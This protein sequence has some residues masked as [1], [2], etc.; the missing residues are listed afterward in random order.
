VDVAEDADTV[1][2]SVR[3]DGAGFD[4]GASAAGFGLLGMRERVALQHGTL[5]V[6]SA[7]GAGT[8]IAVALPVRRQDE[9]AAGMSSGRAAV[10]D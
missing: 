8:T 4:T 7:P 2:V 10:G 6:T 3:D 9:T 5:H 1:S